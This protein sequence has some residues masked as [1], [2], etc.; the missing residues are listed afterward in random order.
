M[1]EE[2]VWLSIKLRPT[3]RDG[4]KA[5]PPLRCGHVARCI[6]RVCLSCTPEVDVHPVDPSPITHSGWSAPDK[7]TRASR[8]TNSKFVDDFV[9]DYFIPTKQRRFL[10]VAVHPSI[11]TSIHPR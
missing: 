8:T 4:R 1:K 5:R 10:S 2:E 6:Q 9:D 11:S 3:L 7:R